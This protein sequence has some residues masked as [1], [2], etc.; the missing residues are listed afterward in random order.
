MNCH[1]FS[2][3]DWPTV[4]HLLVCW[5][6]LVPSHMAGTHSLMHEPAPQGPGFGRHAPSVNATTV[7]KSVSR[8]ILA[9]SSLDS[10]FCRLVLVFDDPSWSQYS[11]RCLV[12]ESPSEYANSCSRLWRVTVVSSCMSWSC[13]CIWPKGRYCFLS[14]WVSFQFQ[15]TCFDGFTVF[16]PWLPVL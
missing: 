8:T 3:Q 6:L 2:K 10:S 9:M 4:W 12:K 13:S 16:L 14:V 11:G 5:V 1:Q 7:V 15:P